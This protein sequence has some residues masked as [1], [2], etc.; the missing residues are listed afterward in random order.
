MI[1]SIKFASQD[2]EKS[3]TFDEKSE[4]SGERSAKSSPAALGVER[5]A[6]KNDTNNISVSDVEAL[7]SIPRKSINAFTSEDIKKA[8]PW[9]RKFYAELGTKSPFFRA[10]FGD[11]RAY[12]QELITPVTKSGAARGSAVNKDTGWNINISRQIHKETTH[13]SSTSVK[14]AVKYLPY[15]DEITQKAVLFDTVMSDKDNEL[16]LMFHSFFKHSARDYSSD[17]KLS[18]ASRRLLRTYKKMFDELSAE[19]MGNNAFGTSSIFSEKVHDSGERSSLSKGKTIR[20]ENEIKKLG[21][22]G[23]TLDVGGKKIRIATDT[24]TVNKNIFSNKGRTKHEVNAR[25]KA[26]PEF[27][28]IIKQSVYYDTD[29]QI[30]GLENE[31][32]KGV[33]A[34]HR[35]KGSYNNYDIEI[36]VR[37]KGSKQ[38]LYEIKFIEKEKSSQQSISME[39]IEKGILDET[40]TIGKQGSSDIRNDKSDPKKQS[41]KEARLQSDLERAREQN[42]KLRA[43]HEQEIS[44]LKA[45]QRE[46]NKRARESRARTAK[47]HSVARSVSR[48]STRLLHPTKTKNILE[49]MQSL[50]FEALSHI[51]LNTEALDSLAKVESELAKLTREDVRDEQK[52]EI[53]TTSND[54]RLTT[55]SVEVNDNLFD[56][57]ISQNTEKKQYF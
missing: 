31:A 1:N 54:E 18:S 9:A 40:D 30:R 49:G 52:Q 44:D 4:K 36:L 25:I 39:Q 35:F 6:I 3:N 28:D 16:S 29:T 51:N 14:N 48:L 7:R 41:A 53:A 42:K 55:R 50:V 27:A 56:N 57:S 22:L 34:M 24:F 32:K 43:R 12:D 8:E 15:I 33:I 5:S 23:I 21:N 2:S 46:S 10:W 45:R 26:I 13:Q 20:L 47:K 37:D 17:E 38:F 19:N 11:W